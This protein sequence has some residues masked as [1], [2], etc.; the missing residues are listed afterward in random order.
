MNDEENITT[1][2]EELVDEQLIKEYN[3]TK[4]DLNQIKFTLITLEDN[5]IE[6]ETSLN[7]CYRVINDGIIYENFEQILRKHSNAYI[8]KF[9]SI[10][11]SKLNDLLKYQINEET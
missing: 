3:I 9:S 6:I 5:C 11:N 4:S 7:H 1:E 10:L 8:D 2:L